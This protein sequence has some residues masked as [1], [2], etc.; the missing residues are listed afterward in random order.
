MPQLAGLH[1]CFSYRT[2]YA[3]QSQN[4]V[5]KVQKKTK[6]KGP[7]QKDIIMWEINLGLRVNLDCVWSSEKMCG[8]EV[9]VWLADTNAD[10]QLPYLTKKH[11]IFQKTKPPPV[12]WC[13]TI[14]AQ[15]T[16]H[17]KSK[18]CNLSKIN[19]ISFSFLS[20][21]IPLFRCYGGDNTK[22]IL[23]ECVIRCES[24]WE[25]KRGT[26]ATFNTTDM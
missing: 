11:I 3:L 10:K 26:E 22:E 14:K 18:S 20:D 12:C 6:A 21:S 1:P 25:K 8:G 13:L 16:H 19:T 7:L 15:T 23:V 17:I 24:M 4:T 2:P 9:L 5:R